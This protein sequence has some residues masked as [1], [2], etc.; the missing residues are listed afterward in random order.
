M[1]QG[2]GTQLILIQQT[3]WADAP[4]Q[5]GFSA[6]MG[7]GPGTQRILIQ[8]TLW[9]DGPGTQRILIIQQTVWEAGF[10]VSRLWAMAPERNRF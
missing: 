6:S 5:A 9:A 3:V 10:S 7:Q 8:Q 4:N 2:L 1:G